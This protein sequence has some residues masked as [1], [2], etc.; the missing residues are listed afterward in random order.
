LNPIIDRCYTIKFRLS[1]LLLRARRCWWLFG[2]A[3]VAGVSIMV[4]RVDFEATGLGTW[5]SQAGD[6][7]YN[8]A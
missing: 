5:A 6:R 8:P 4:F 3:L 2:F 7:R 1:Y